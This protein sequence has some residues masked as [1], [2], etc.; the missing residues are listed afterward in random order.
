M[1]E[2]QFNEIRN[3][4]SGND[5]LAKRI[6]LADIRLDDNSIQNGVIYVMGNRVPVSPTFF[7]RLGQMVGL[8]VSLLNRMSKNG[9]REPQ[10]KLLE[11]VKLYTESRD[12]G[13]TEYILVGDPEKHQVIDIVKA[14]RYTRLANGTMFEIAEM[15][16]NEVPGLSVQSVDRNGSGMNINLIHARD[17]AFEKFGPDEVFRFGITLANT[18]KSSQ[19]KDFAQRLSCDN[20]MITPIP[21]DDTPPLNPRS[22]GGPGGISPDT[23]R[24]I[25]DRAHIWSDRGFIPVSF[26]DRLERATKTRASFA[27]MQ[28]AFNQV[29][30]QIREEDA[31]RRSWI[32]KA[33]KAKH[34]PM[35]EETERRIVAKGYN[36]NQLKP[37]EKKFIRTGRSVWD[38]VNDLTFIGSHDVGLQMMNPRKFKVTAGGLFVKD[39]DLA[40][41]SMMDI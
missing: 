28:G 34:F 38:L 16:L 9:D 32:V 15:L 20:G 24:D 36:P 6:H 31:D 2:N 11:A 25:I 8:N 17:K 33:L 7:T 27:E 5:P 19:I 22:G 23:F 35:L 14:D 10:I 39:W 4:L 1:D 12:G 41:V 37:E 29:E 13:T 3:E 18:E 26:E 30:W 40:N 21:S